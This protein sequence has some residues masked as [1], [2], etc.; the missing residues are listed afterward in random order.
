M[1]TV[2]VPRFGRN[3]FDGRLNISPIKV[4]ATP[5]ICEPHVPMKR[6]SDLATAAEAE[7]VEVDTGRDCNGW[8]AV[9]KV[10]MRFFPSCR[11]KL[12]EESPVST[13]SW[14]AS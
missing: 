9:S 6:K 7:V 11:A 13:I 10:S 3:S 5:N 12:W 2:N 4:S 14:V 1:S 8:S